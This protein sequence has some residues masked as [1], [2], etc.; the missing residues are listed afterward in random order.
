MNIVNY[1][2][3]AFFKKEAT[4]TGILV[5]LSLLIT[6]IQTNGISYITANII[7]SVEQ[8][9]KKMT[10]E[11]FNY[12][13]A[14]STLFFVI[15]YIYKT[16][17]NNLITKLFQWVKHEIFK[18]ILKTNNENM[19]N[20]NFIEFITPITRIS[21]SFYVLF[22]DIITVIIPI[23]AFLLIISFYFLYENPVFGISFFIANLVLFYYIY[24][25]WNDLRKAKNDQEEVVNKN[26]KFIID[27]LNN[28]DK[29]IYRGETANEIS[30]FTTLTDKAISEGINFLDI[31][32]THTS[33]LTF[34][35]YII[36]FVSL[37]YLIQLQYTKKIKT[38]TFIT[39]V[40]ILLLYRDK[41]IS[42]INN[43]PDWL[44]FIGR[45]EYI[46]DDFNEMLGK[47]IDINELI[48]KTYNSHDLKFNN[49]IFDNVTFYYESRK[50]TPVFSNSSFNINIDQK[51]IG[52]TGLSGKGKT[53]FA[54][55]LL[56]L[57]DPVSGKIYIDGVD[58]STIDP[59][60]IRQNITYVNQNSKLFDKKIMD[61][62]MYGCKDPEICEIFLKEIMKYPKIQGLYKNVDIYNSNAGSLG[63]NLSGGQR[64][65]VNIISGLI[66]T[67]KILI[68]D[69]PTNALDIELKDEIIQLIAEFRKY[70]KCII[71]ISHDKDTFR[72]F[73]E[74][75]NM[76]N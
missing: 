26:E 61:N 63:E 52:I 51:I 68:L 70:K 76:N 73:D 32:T 21:T 2:L 18:I 40:T 29:V 45:I 55:L 4:N 36:I 67:S 75:L 43:L 6:L 41:I 23:M 37:F 58:I 15:Y 35:V 60:Y 48:N 20:V 74:T 5:L 14:L 64:Q 24:A 66:S 30:N 59:D 16:Y 27:I 33:I 62:I 11:F 69:E 53:S 10:M 42:T 47:D 34:L 1:L 8:N 39:F 57:Y 50:T 54:K 13:I 49:I 56:R 12:F 38:T 65:V 9:S 44:E 17:Q 28:I 31:I 46:T 71:I 3:Y 72:L 19:K 22:Y 7:Q 25:N